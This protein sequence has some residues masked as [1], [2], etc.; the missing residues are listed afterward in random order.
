MTL[1][2]EEGDRRIELPYSGGSDELQAEVEKLKQA[3]SLTKLF[4]SKG[5]F[6]AVLKKQFA[7]DE[8][9]VVKRLE[10][11]TCWGTTQQIHFR[12]NELQSA[13]EKTNVTIQSHPTKI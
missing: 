11:F 10:I 12:M 8:K 7:P 9:P 13:I 5:P 6:G 4:E 2:P 3:S 1:A